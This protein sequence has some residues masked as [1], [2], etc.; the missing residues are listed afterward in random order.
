M[1][2]MLCPHCLKDVDTADPEPGLPAICPECAGI[3]HETLELEE[4]DYEVTNPD[5]NTHKDPEMQGIVR[6]LEKRA[7]QERKQLPY[8][9][10]R[11]PIE[12]ATGI[13]LVGGGLLVMGL[14]F[15]G[16][17]GEMSSFIYRVL[18]GLLLIL[19]GSLCLIFRP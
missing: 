18:G 15:G 7:R 6:A 2:R 10:K 5:E 19:L 8:R 9:R 1:P 13:P 17:G 14:A 16:G 3:L 4:P 11:F 12:T